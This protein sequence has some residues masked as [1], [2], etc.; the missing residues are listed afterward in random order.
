MTHEP[1]VP[2]Q[3]PIE[4]IRRAPARRRSYASPRLI[5]WGSLTELTLGGSGLDIDY[6]FITTKA[7]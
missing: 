7:V 3:D 5:E 1:P 4:D 6:D 2:E